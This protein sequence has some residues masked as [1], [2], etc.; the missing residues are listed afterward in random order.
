MQ[1][2]LA[3]LGLELPSDQAHDRGLATT[4]RSHEGR[5]LATRDGEGHVIQDQAFAVAKAHVLEF[6]EGG[7]VGCGHKK[8]KAS[9]NWLLH[10]KG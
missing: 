8:T 9:M 3:L 4:R 2:H 1:Q 5:D 6:D 10:H 7:R